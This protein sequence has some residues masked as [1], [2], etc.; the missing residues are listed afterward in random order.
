MYKGFMKIGIF[1]LLL[2]FAMVAAFPS[3][4]YIGPGIATGTVGVILGIL[5]SV[6]LALFALLWYPI[7][8]FLKRRKKNAGN[9]SGQ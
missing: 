6:V 8:R 7:K 3:Y 1:I 5:A 9:I 4:A 2:L